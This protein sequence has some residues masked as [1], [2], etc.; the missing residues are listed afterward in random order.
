MIK[1]KNIYGHLLTITS[2]KLLVGKYCWKLG[3]YKQAILHDLSKY[4]YVELKTGFKY[5][6]GSCSPITIEK[7]LNGI[8]YG[9]LHHQ[10]KNKHHI[11]Y[12]IDINRYCEIPQNYLLE[13]V[14]DRVA[15][16]KTYLK[17]QF[18]NESPLEYF[19]RDPEINNMNIKSK[20]QLETYLKIIAEKGI[21]QGLEYIKQINH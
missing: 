7:K 3:L 11:H 5:Y 10:A 4:S 16:S 9:W 1:F 20:N 13:M 15:A 12:W 2:H 19:Y 14:C 21:N 18:R 8:S 17:N 6:Q